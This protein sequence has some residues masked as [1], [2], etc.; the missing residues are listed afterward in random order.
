MARAVALTLVMLAFGSLLQAGGPLVICHHQGLVWDVSKVLEYRIDPGPLG[1]AVNPQKQVADAFAA[2]GLVV[3]GLT[4][5]AVPLASDVSTLAEFQALRS[6]G[7]LGGVIMFDHDGSILD[8][9]NGAGTSDSVLGGAWPV[10]S[11]SQL[12]RFIAV[13]NGKKAGDQKKLTYT[14]VH[15]VGHA[16]GLDHSQINHTAAANGKTSDDN[17]LPTMFPTGTD[18]N[19][20]LAALNPDDVA[21][22]TYLYAKGALPKGYG[23]LVG[24]LERSGAPV[25]GANV[26]AVALFPGP[27]GPGED[28]VR[29]YSCVTDYL[30]RSDGTFE[31][32]VPPG[33]YRLLLEPIHTR[34]VA[35]SSVGPYA[36]VPAD[37]SFVNPVAPARLA[38]VHTV[39]AGAV[40]QIGK[41]SVP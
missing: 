4:T 1:V 13:F 40:T 41:V 36:R 19:A 37:R 18:D 6:S 9:L 35:G 8:D 12:V 38:P 24:T 30:M 14:L 22:A 28:P 39:T 7:R 31:I 33:N 21:W 10:A 32:P 25:L 27:T 5:K 20:L 15:E 16:L 11:G 26:V 3:P 34:F 2:W 23:L 29:R 17:E